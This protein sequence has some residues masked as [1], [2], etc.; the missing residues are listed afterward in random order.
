MAGCIELLRAPPRPPVCLAGGDGPGTCGALIRR[1]R[2]PLAPERHAV[3]ASSSSSWARPRR[4]PTCPRPARRALDDGGGGKARI[5]RPPHTAATTTTTAPTHTQTLTLPARAGDRGGRLV[6][7]GC[8]PCGAREKGANRFWQLRRLPAAPAPV[9][10]AGAAARGRG[11]REA[12]EEKGAGPGSRGGRGSWG[13]YDSQGGSRHRGPWGRSLLRWRGRARLCWWRR[14][15]RGAE[16][17]LLSTALEGEGAE[18]TALRGG[19]RG[20]CGAG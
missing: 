18:T 9:G 8:S 7:P 13:G 4:G 3:R 14:R 15:R 1:A 16:D 10:R 2:V 5:W 19:A 20:R 11:R 6:Q 12:Q 17:T